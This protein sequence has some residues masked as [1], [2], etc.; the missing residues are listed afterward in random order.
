MWCVR[1]CCLLSMCISPGLGG[2]PSDGGGLSPDGS[3]EIRVWL[4]CH[5][6]E[7]HPESWLD[8]RGGSAPPGAVGS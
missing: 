6:V 7:R 4:G 3:I 5:E 1:G 8:G 2:E